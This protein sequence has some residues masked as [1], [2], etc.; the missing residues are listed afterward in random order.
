[1][2]NAAPTDDLLD[3]ARYRRKLDMAGR[4]SELGLARRRYPLV[5]DGL[6]HDYH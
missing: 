6:T 3:M 1:M 4:W 2:L 5:V